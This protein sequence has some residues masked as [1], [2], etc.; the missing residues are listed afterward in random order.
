MKLRRGDMFIGIVIL[1]IV[2]LWFFWPAEDKP[3][4]IAHVKVGNEVI[5]SINLSE[6]GLY[7]V[8]GI[9]G[10]GILEVKD[11]RIRMQEM[12]KEICPNGICCRLTGW[13]ESAYQSIVCLPNRIIVT[14]SSPEETDI[15]LISS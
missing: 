13:I 8:Q 9:P 5:M 10:S 15:D 1:T 11:G 6:N 4:R 12:S 7:P 3:G 2:T 14:L